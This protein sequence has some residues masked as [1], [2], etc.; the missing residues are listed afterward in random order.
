M[1]LRSSPLKVADPLDVE[2]ELGD[3][4]SQHGDSEGV[5]EATRNI[6]ININIHININS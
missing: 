4:I 6:N 2:N 5:V 1:G 3:S